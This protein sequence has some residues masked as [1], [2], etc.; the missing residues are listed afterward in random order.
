MTHIPTGISVH[1]QDE[2]SQHKNKSKALK[3]VKAKLYDIQSRKVQEER[4]T[5]RRQQIG[6]AERSERIRTYNFPQDRVT[7]HRL[8]ITVHGIEDFMTGSDSLDNMIENLIKMEEENHL[9][10]L[11]RQNR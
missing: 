6:T 2:R 11:V 1:I 10:E 3:L 7:D 4:S 8:G 9:E 5:E